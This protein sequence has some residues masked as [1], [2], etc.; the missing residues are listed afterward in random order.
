MK[1]R[2]ILGYRDPQWL[3]AFNPILDVAISGDSHEP[4]FSPCLKIARSI[5]QGY[6]LGIEHYADMG[7]LD[8][9]GGK[10]QGHSLY[11]ALDISKGGALDLNL[12][13]GRGFENESDKWVVKMI[14]GLPI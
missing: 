3:V 14:L 5:A 12:G 2:P 6:A 10:Q 13:V 11:A 1:L 9:I 8:H 4:Q 7:P